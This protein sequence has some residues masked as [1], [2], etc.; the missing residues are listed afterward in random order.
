M[1]NNLPENNEPKVEEKTTSAKKSKKNI[2]IK[3]SIIT[4]IVAAVAV[5]GFFAYRIFL[6]KDP[7]KVTSKAI[8]GLKDGIAD[9]KK[10]NSEIANILEGD[11]AFEI[12]SNIKLDMPKELGSDYL[13]K[14]LA[15][16]DTEGQEVK[17][18][19][20][21]KEDNKTIIDM[22]ALVDAAKVYFKFDG[23]S[24]YYY[25]KLEEA[26]S[27]ID[28]E[29]LPVLPEYDYEN[30]IDYLADAVDGALSSKDFDKEKD[31]LTIGEKDVKVTKYTAEIDEVKLKAIADKFFDKVLSDKKLLDV[32]A[33][34]TDEDVDDIKEGIKEFKKLKAS[35]LGEV[36]FDYSVYV[37]SSGDVVGYGFGYEGVEIVI[38][39]YKDVLSIQLLAQGMR[40]SL[41]LE[42]KSDEHYV[43]TLNAMGMITGKLDIKTKL[44]TVKKNEEYNY[45][46]DA[47]LELNI[48]GQD[49]IK[50]SLEVDTT[51][52][53][54]DKVDTS[55][56]LGAKNIEE[57]TA[58]EEAELES[59]LSRSN[60]YK[61]ISGLMYGGI[62]YAETYKAPTNTTLNY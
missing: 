14:F 3:A 35:D 46:L 30:I 2:A 27:S 25:T 47:D 50:G 34:L 8:R 51:I 42:K 62:N 44:D 1:D 20:Q 17:F 39:D 33:K 52:K 15:Q 32:I 29:E 53:K 40:A 60:T 58:A 9:V 49:P 38:A 24:N 48:Q 45:T 7:V 22:K 43:V 41:E 54:I 56:K 6:S 4:L 10:D 28:L 12:K 55:A 11:D 5:G 36:N 61:F 21:A 31:E 18:D 23:M 19:I 26:T 57:L 37:T 16:A 59:E 13:I